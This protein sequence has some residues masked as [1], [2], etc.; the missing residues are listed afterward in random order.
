MPTTDVANA[1]VDFFALNKTG[2]DP[3]TGCGDAGSSVDAS[4]GGTD[5]GSVTSDASTGGTDASSVGVDGGVPGTDAGVVGID[6]SSL[7]PD[8]GTTGSD[9]GVLASDASVVDSDG[10]GGSNGD[11]GNGCGCR[12]GPTDGRLG[13]LLAAPF[14]AAL[15]MVLRRRRRPRA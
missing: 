8:A 2:P 6:A 11:S 7:G 14:G 10:G 4:T 13:A 5:A 1:I 3:G 12:V 15:G 9:G